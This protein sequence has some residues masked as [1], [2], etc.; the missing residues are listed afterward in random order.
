MSWIVDVPVSAS[1]GGVTES[2]ATA[3]DAN[4]PNGSE[5]GG[6]FMGLL[7]G[8][9]GHSLRIRGRFMILSILLV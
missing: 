7:A 5:G 2:V 1:S 3:T 9:G 6:G 8:E 4:G